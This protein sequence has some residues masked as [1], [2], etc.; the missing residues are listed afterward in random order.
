MCICTKNS[1][2]ISYS[3][4]QPNEMVLGNNQ[5]QST[6]DRFDDD[7]L[8]VEIYP[9]THHMRSF[10]SQALLL[11]NGLH[12]SNQANRFVISLRPV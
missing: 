4:A 1:T 2:T 7:Y 12:Y 3:K 11:H 6:K 5:Y 10:Q 9:Y 8:I